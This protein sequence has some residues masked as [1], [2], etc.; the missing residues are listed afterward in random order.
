MYNPFCMKTRKLTLPAYSAFCMALLGQ[1]NSSAQ[2]VITDF[3]PDLRMMN[4]RDDGGIK[5]TIAIDIDSNGITDLMFR[6]DEITDYWGAYF[7]VDVEFSDAVTGFIIGSSGF[8]PYDLM[9]GDTIN[10]IMGI[11]YG[12]V[13]LYKLEA[14]VLWYGTSTTSYG[15][16]QKDEY[17]GLKL[18]LDGETKFGWVR[19]SVANLGDTDI[20]EKVSTGSPLT[21]FEMGYNN[22]VDEPTVCDAG[23]LPEEYTVTHAALRDDIDANNFSDLQFHFYNYLTPD[24]SELRFFIVPSREDIINFSVEEALTLEES[25][26]LSI[27][28]SSIVAYSDNSFSLPES[29]LDINGDTFSP[30]KYYSGFYLKIPLA[31]DTSHLSL[32]SAIDVMKPQLQ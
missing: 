25:R 28:P 20:W 15:P 21:I 17:L 14:E 26:Y 10:S 27:L 9:R 7:D 6:Y 29:F 31:G 24:F 2:V 13:E 4:W 3:E 12:T 23:A 19:L 30:D 11:Y 8:Y 5:D 22:S 32:S 1:T 16:F 18:N